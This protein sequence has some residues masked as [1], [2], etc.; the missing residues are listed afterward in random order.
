MEINENDR[1]AWFSKGKILSNLGKLEESLICF[2]RAIALKPNYYEAWCEK[3]VVLEQLERWEEAEHCFDRSL[4][5][6]CHDLNETLQDELLLLAT[7]Q[8]KTPQG[9]YNQACFHAI[10]GNVDCAISYLEEA[11]SFN[12]A[13]YGA[14]ALED[15]DFDSIRDDIRFQKLTAFFLNSAFCPLI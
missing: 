1:F 9:S 5:A 7:P 6:F 11:I 14:M 2:D 15:T 3:G 12:G 4:G 10:Q 8:D 13:K